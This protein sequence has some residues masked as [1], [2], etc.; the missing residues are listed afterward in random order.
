MSN[1]TEKVGQAGA[2]VRVIGLSGAYKGNEY[3]IKG[4]DFTIGRANDCNLV[5]DESTVSAK[6]AKIT[7]VGDRYEIHDLNST[8]GTFVN[9]VKVERKGL[10]TNDKLK[11]DVFEF[12][13]INPNEVERTVVSQAPDFDKA[14]KTVVRPAAE[15]PRVAAAPPPPAAQP[16]VERPRQQPHAGHPEFE[17]KGSIIAGLIV[18]LIV[19]YIFS[20]GG[21]FVGSW[22]ATSF[23]VNMIQDSL[24]NALRGFPLIHLHNA[25]LPWPADTQVMLTAIV[26]I[27]CI[28]LG[29]L[30]GGVVT[31]SIG[32]K[33]RFLTAIVFTIFYAGIALAVNFGLIN[34]N[35]DAWKFIWPDVGLG[36][37]DPLIRMLVAIGYFAGV[38]FVISFIGTLLGK[39][40]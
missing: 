10:R 5:L 8:N 25:Y 11:F 12:R 18:G 20:F 24:M 4:P 32:R 28:A 17:K 14:A 9:G 37:T 27:V 2:E 13:Y 39:R 38:T 36:L 23:N 30:L 31:Q 33:N 7:K 26:I 15:A 34:W 1:D 21:A 6:H 16:A 22:S 3:I 19:A 29:L 40:R 35:F